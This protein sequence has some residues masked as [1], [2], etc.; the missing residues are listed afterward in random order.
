MRHAFAH[1][2]NGLGMEAE[3]NANWALNACMFDDGEVSTRTF[4]YTALPSNLNRADT[5]R[6]GSFIA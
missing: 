1:H 5:K 3:A 4:E 6:Q 2:L